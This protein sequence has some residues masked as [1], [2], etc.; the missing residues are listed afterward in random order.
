MTAYLDSVLYAKEYEHVSFKNLL[1]GLKR[2]PKYQSIFFK[3]FSFLNLFF[4]EIVSLVET[5]RVFSDI[6]I[7][8]FIIVKS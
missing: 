6:V 2:E 7:K 8:T 4:S 5:F 1:C 3:D